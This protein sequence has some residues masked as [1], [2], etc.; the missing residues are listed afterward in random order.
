MPQRFSMELIEIVNSMV[1]GHRWRSPPTPQ[2]LESIFRQFFEALNLAVIDTVM[3]HENVHMDRDLISCY[4]SLY[5]ASGE[6]ALV[7]DV[8]QSAS[9]MRRKLWR[10]C[11][12]PQHA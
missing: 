1:L 7:V 10:R 2:K 6:P 12:T 5:R 8:C 3:G 4:A 9:R 11:T